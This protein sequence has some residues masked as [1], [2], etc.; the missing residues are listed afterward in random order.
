MGGREVNLSRRKIAK[1]RTTGQERKWGSA[2]EGKAH[3]RLRGKTQRKDREQKSKSGETDKRDPPR[4][5]VD[6]QIKL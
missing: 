2:K 4:N 6:S 1:K 3:K 5:N